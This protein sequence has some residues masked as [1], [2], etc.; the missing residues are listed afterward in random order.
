VETDAGSSFQS[1]L[2]KC[3]QIDGKRFPDRYLETLLIGIDGVRLEICSVLVNQKLVVPA[4]VAPAMT[5][6]AAVMPAD[7]YRSRTSRIYID[8]LKLTN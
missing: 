4:A 6:M 1:I 7:D 2:V 5:V 8:S 3:G